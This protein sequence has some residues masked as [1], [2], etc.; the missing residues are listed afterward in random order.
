VPGV[1]LEVTLS[2]SPILRQLKVRLRRLMQEGFAGFLLSISLFTGAAILISV[3]LH[4]RAALEEEVRNEILSTVDTRHEPSDATAEL[5]L[6][7]SALAKVNAGPSPK[8]WNCPSLDQK[9]TPV[10][11]LP[12]KLVAEIMPDIVKVLDDHKNGDWS[13]SKYAKNGISR[14]GENPEKLSWPELG[15]GAVCEKDNDGTFLMIPAQTKAP[16]EPYSTRIVKAA[17]LSSYLQPALDKLDNKFHGQKPYSYFVQAYFISPDSLLRIRSYRNA[18]VCREFNKARLWAAKSYF[19]HF[20]DFPLDDQYSTL[21]YIDYGGNGV[22]RTTCRVLEAPNGDPQFSRGSFLGI[23][24]MDFKVPSSQ[25]DLMRRHLFFETALVSFPVPISNDIDQIAVNLGASSKE[26]EAQASEVDNRTEPSRAAAVPGDDKPT[27]GTTVSEVGEPSKREIA[28]EKAIDMQESM[29]SVGAVRESLHAELKS[30]DEDKL[31]REIT[32]F[33][34]QGRETFL[35]PLGLSGG[36]F[37]GLIFYPR[38]PKLR[39]IDDFFAVLGFLMAGAALA[40]AG[41][42]WR[43]LPKATDLRER[44]SLFR[45]L[46]VGILRVDRKDYILECNDRAEELFDRKLPKPGVSVLPINFQDLIQLRL[47][48]NKKDPQNGQR[49]KPISSEEVH[50]MRS[51]GQSSEYYACLTNRAKRKWVRVLATPIMV[52]QPVRRRTN[53]TEPVP[54]SSAARRQTSE[55]KWIGT[56]ATVCEVS[57][58]AVIDL[59][60]HLEEKKLGKEAL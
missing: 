55:I 35:L 58:E 37:Q 47:R 10:D 54:S 50:Q 48:E 4:D 18:S 7:G 9:C 3:Y 16:D 11:Q 52:A 2:S 33:A 41:Y 51:S 22:V 6:I 57:P 38:S 39:P 36:T 59:E 24:C 28:Q 56:F 34:F 60:R 1:P 19:S 46:Q 13:G 12:G 32:H 45:N 25:I 21:A 5:G 14:T 49:Y 44:L 42:N 27:K 29:L 53:K 31:V 8:E 40:S 17:E 20:W 30:L 23:L 26:L 43:L 15:N